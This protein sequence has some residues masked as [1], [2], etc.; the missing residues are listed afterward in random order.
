MVEAWTSSISSHFGAGSFGEHLEEDSCEHL[1][2]NRNK[3]TLRVRTNN[4]IYNTFSNSKLMIL[5]NCLLHRYIQ[6]PVP[7][8]PTPETL[9]G[10]FSSTAALRFVRHGPKGKA[11]AMPVPPPGAGVAVER[12]PPGAGGAGPSFKQHRL[13]RMRHGG[14]VAHKLLTDLQTICIDAWGDPKTVSVPQ[15]GLARCFRT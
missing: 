10:S 13:G 2:G 7:E 5:V 1:F 12:P 11:P 6:I 8:L 9:H 4:Y 15:V 3:L 14:Q